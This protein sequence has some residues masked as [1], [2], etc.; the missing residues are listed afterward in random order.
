MFAVSSATFRRCNVQRMWT[1]RLHESRRGD[2]QGRDLERPFSRQSQNQRGETDMR[3]FIILSVAL[4]VSGV[5]TA[6]AQDV[7]YNFAQ[8]EDFS[9]Y[10]TY[11][12]VDVKGV[13]HADPLT[14][15]Q[16]MAAIDGALAT[17]GLQKTDSDTADLYID[18]QTAISTEKQFTSYNTGWGYGPGWQ[19]AEGMGMVAG[20][21][22]PQPTDPHPRYTLGN[23]PLTCMTLPRRSWC[24]EESLARPSILRPS[25][26][27]NR[28]TSQKL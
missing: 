4:L 1:E 21:P 8:D 12:W 13:D 27:S 15:K 11:K 16:I 20:W 3:K 9:K 25:P 22:Q 24:G 6:V 23:W 7:R 18:I 10:K 14:E 26:K 17:K 5:I 19:A 28:R 2:K